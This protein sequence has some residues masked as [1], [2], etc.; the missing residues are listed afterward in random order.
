RCRGHNRRSQTL[1][2]QL[3]SQSSFRPES[4]AV[5]SFCTHLAAI[6]NWNLRFRAYT[7]A[8][9]QDRLIVRSPSMRPHPRLFVILA[10]LILLGSAL[11]GRA[12]ATSITLNTPT[13]L[14]P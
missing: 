4:I 1:H 11:G 7:L 12:E 5:Q 2:V 9:N 10:V 3:H 8:L 13:G 6:P 14:S